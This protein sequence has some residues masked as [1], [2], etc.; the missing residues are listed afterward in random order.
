MYTLGTILS[1]LP[2]FFT[3]YPYYPYFSNYIA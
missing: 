1:V 2:I 3:D